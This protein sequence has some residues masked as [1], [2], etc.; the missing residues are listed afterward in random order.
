MRRGSAAF[1]LLARPELRAGALA[2][3]STPASA[4]TPASGHPTSSATRTHGLGLGSARPILV[5]ESDAATAKTLVEQMTNDG[6]QAELARSAEH[7]RARAM[8]CPPRLVVLG[9]LDSSRG[10]LELLEEIR[11]TARERRVW[12]PSMPVIVIG[13]SVSELD[14]LRAFEAGADDFVAR[15]AHYL[16]LR[17]RMRAL[18]RRVE[19]MSLSAD[20]LT[21]GSLEVDMS[22]HAASVH[23][24][25]VQLRRLEFE[26]LVYLATDPV[27]VCTK[28]EL[29]R[30]VWGYRSSGSTRTVD[31]HASRLRRKLEEHGGRWVIN[32]WGIGYRLH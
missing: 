32:V 7:A 17:A 21:V 23:G 20:R 29:L 14:M 4:P 31:S 10:Q 16:E 12:A 6:Y 25:P 8:W 26:L 19:L 13:A 27:R 30:A 5:V 2:S 1:A 24:L 15:P 3:A 18:L 22:G 28:Q 11:Q 9:D